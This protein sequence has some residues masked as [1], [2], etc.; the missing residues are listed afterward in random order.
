MEGLIVRALLLWCLLMVISPG[1]DAAALSAALVQPG[2][3][4]T[5][6]SMTIQG[7]S[8]LAAGSQSWGTY[9]NVSGTY[10]IGPGVIIST[11]QVK[12]YADGPDLDP[13]DAGTDFH[14]PATAA[15]TAILTPIGGV[16]SYHDV[17]QLDV[18]FSLDAT[19][20]S[21]IFN[22]VFG[23]NEYPDFVGFDF[24]D[25]FGLLVN[26]TNIA[27]VGGLPVDIDNPDFQL[28][29]FPGPWAPYPGTKLNGVLAPGV[30]P[31]LT[32]TRQL[33]RGAS[34]V[35]T[36][37]IADKADGLYDTTA[38]F[39]GLAGAVLGILPGSAI[40]AGGAA[41]AKMCLQHSGGANAGL[42]LP[43]TQARAGAAETAS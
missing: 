38:Y 41:A 30:V 43:A 14:S 4:V 24:I 18:S 3:G 36:L 17:T 12:D 27:F 15:Q 40:N 8:L 34:G 16:G 33:S 7:N 32:F 22:V 25:C 21:I 28:P 42:G 6:T 11:G 35:L 37:I 1:G 20:D 9:T 19:H 31:L 10:G 29:V 39:N 2:T 26:G 5:I 23:S 13:T